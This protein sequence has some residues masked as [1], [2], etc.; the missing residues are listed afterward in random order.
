M[1]LHANYH[2]SKRQLWDRATVAR[3]GA[4]QQEVQ[5]RQQHRVPF[6]NAHPGSHW[7]LRINLHSAVV[8]DGVLFLFC[9]FRIWAPDYRSPHQSDLCGSSISSIEDAAN[10]LHAN[11]GGGAP[12][13]DPLHRPSPPPAG[14]GWEV[15]DHGRRRRPKEILF[16]LVEGEKMGFHRMC[17][18]S[19]YSGFSGEP[20][21]G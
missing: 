19:K 11:R 4:K 13:P 1:E 3:G 17:L 16:E 7:W 18:Y 5:G 9:S 12:G 6:G 8:R 2:H 21:N 14:F 15:P 20:N 10:R